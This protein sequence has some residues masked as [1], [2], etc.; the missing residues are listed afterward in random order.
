ML[1]ELFV[2]WCRQMS[3]LL[4]LGG[5]ERRLRRN[6]LVVEAPA[7]GG[8]AVVVTRR[9]RHRETLLGRYQL[10]EPGPA[11]GGRSRPVVLR[12]PPTM[13]LEQEITLPL[14]AEPAAE[15]VLGYEMDRVTPFTADEVYWAWSIARRDRAAGRLHVRLSLVPRQALASLVP[16]LAAIG[17]M[18]GVLETSAADGTPRLIALRHPPAGRRRLLA[19]AA[20]CCMVLALV[21]I[22]E[23]FA[24]Q[25]LALTRVARQ[26][27]A[28]RPAVAQAEALRRRIAGQS[29][30]T[31][32]VAAERGRVGDVLAVLATITDIVPD[33]AF[34]NRFSWAERKL[35]L[36]GEAAGAARLMT[37]L[38]ADPSLR[39]TAFATPVTPAASRRG[40]R[41]SIRAEAAP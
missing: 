38:A 28:V 41:F 22:V 2:W 35:V 21:A 16:A 37:A 8:D 18:P 11:R 27:E 6:A 14:L 19:G 12:L 13:L 3:D 25:S 15:Q 26:I 4:G 9:R 24:L 29:A 7:R 30:A 10:D 23:P 39:D 31:D 20:L 5:T 17:L 40:E 32:I 36:D 1:K 34:L 33:D